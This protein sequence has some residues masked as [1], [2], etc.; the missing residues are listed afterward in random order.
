MTVFPDPVIEMLLIQNLLGSSAANYRATVVEKSNFL[1]SIIVLFLLIALSHRAAGQAGRKIAPPQPSEASA[2][3]EPEFIPDPNRDEYQLVFAAGY[4]LNKLMKAKNIEDQWW[5]Y[6]GSFIGR[7][8]KAGAQGYR[9]ITIALAPTVAIMRRD[10]RQY[11]YAIL[12]ITNRNHSVFFDAG[13][14]FERQYAPLA[15]EGFT[16]ADYFVIDDSCWGGG[17]NAVEGQLEPLDCNYDS[18]VVL[19]QQKNLEVPHAYE[20]VY[21]PRTFSKKKL[22]GGLTEQLNVALKRNL[23]PTHMLTKFE[24]LTQSVSW[25][26]SLTD[27][28]EMEI[29]GG[30]VKR[31]VNE[32]AMLGYR[33]MIRPHPSFRAAIMHRK[34]GV[35]DPASYVWVSEKGLEHEL[36]TLQEQGVIY[37]M[38]YG[39][40]GGWSGSQLIFEK[41]SGSDG[42]KRQYRILTIA[43][44]QV[45]RDAESRVEFQLTPDSRNSMQ[46]L[47]RLGKEGFA[48]RD[49]FGCDIGNQKNRVARA[50]VL[51]ERVEL[52]DDHH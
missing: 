13:A 17:W 46:T 32:L 25:R 29:V 15:K 36:P 44:T 4:D 34:K 12:E 30:D 18:V 39:C 28:Y 27:E 45:E 42:T 50:K 10:D 23:Y 19:E 21:Q 7:L 16:I 2:K 8:N 37:R 47:N 43:L 35:T 52:G 48:V 24:V 51:L 31:R 3:L 38:N 6:K 20:I 22:E 14:E 41:P 33:L 49:F 5:N 1:A 40:H 9:L 11:R 26:D